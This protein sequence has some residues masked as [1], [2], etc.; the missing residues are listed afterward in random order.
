MSKYTQLYD[1]DSIEFESGENWNLQCCDCG[2]VHRFDFK[3]NKK[4][5]TVTLRRDKRRTSAVRRGKECKKS[6]ASLQKGIK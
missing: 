3:I 1:G 5:M 4:K 2:L 6:I